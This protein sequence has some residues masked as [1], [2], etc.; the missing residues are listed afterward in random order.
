MFGVL[1]IVHTRET[2]EGSKGLLVKP[3]GL[4]R[5]TRSGGAGVLKREHCLM[6]KNDIDFELTESVQD[7]ETQLHVIES[8]SYV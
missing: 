3:Y 1:T 2:R 7:T 5:S 4:G 6:H 8:L